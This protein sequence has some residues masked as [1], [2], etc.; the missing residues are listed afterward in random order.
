MPHWQTSR[1]LIDLARPQVMG[2]V[3][4]TPDSFSDGG[5]H[6]TTNAALAHCEALIAQGADIL[7]LGAESTRPGADPLTLEQELERLL[8]VLR[9]AVTLGVPVSVD[10][11]KPGVMQAALDTGADIINDV[12]ALRWRDPVHGLTGA[13]VVSQHPSCGVCLMHMHGNPQTMQISPM[14]GAIVASVRDFLAD[15][16]QALV[17]QGVCKS[18]IAIDPGI[19]FGKTVAQNFSL[20]AQQQTLVVPGV[21]LLAGWSRK[22]SLGAVTGAAADDRL[23]ASAVAATLAVQNGAHIVRVHDVHA[24]VQALRVLAAAQSEK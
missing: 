9:V 6:A 11:Y 3:N 7:D 23:V 8:P 10:T 24:T 12:W 4:I 5:Q 17:E 1:T 21:A 18:R 20:L 15:A 22:S 13:Q 2:I 14:E 16:S 19:G